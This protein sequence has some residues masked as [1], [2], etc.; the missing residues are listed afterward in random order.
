M[1][2]HLTSNVS[3]PPQPIL[4]N[5]TAILSTLAEIARTLEQ[6]E[7]YDEAR[8]LHTLREPIILMHSANERLRYRQQLARVPTNVLSSAQKDVLYALTSEELHH[9]NRGEKGAFS[10]YLPNYAESTGLSEDQCGRI[11]KQLDE[12]GTLRRGEVRTPEGHRRITVEI[13]PPAWEPWTIHREEPRNQ[14]G[15]R[16]PKCVKCGSEKF[17]PVA[18]ECDGC[19]ITY[20]ELPYSDEPVYADTTPASQAEDD[21]PTSNLSEHVYTQGGGTLTRKLRIHPRARSCGI[22]LGTRSLMMILPTL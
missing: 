20:D 22:T 3:L 5:P 11:I 1:L 18:W 16:K 4:A 7:M 21:T 12:C 10:P 15:P 19:G 9:R 8:A 2:P 6:R 14:G 17:K 13:L